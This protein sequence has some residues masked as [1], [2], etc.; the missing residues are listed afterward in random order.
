MSSE[1]I[2]Q[3]QYN[4]CTS[5]RREVRPFANCNLTYEQSA[6]ERETAKVKHDKNKNK[7][8]IDSLDIYDCLQLTNRRED[9][10]DALELSNIQA[11]T[12]D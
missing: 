1:V 12:I 10:K 2:R 6:K 7:F 5:S 8:N 9:G 3:I 4:T 11:N